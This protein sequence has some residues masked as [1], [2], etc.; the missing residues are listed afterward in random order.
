MDP[1]LKECLEKIDRRL[2][3]VERGV[4]AGKRSMRGLELAMIT[5]MNK[6]GGAIHDTRSHLGLGP[7][8]STGEE[9]DDEVT[10]HDSPSEKMK[11]EFEQFSMKFPDDEGA[12]KVK[13]SENPEGSRLSVEGDDPTKVREIIEAARKRHPVIESLRPMGRALRSRTGKLVTLTVGLLSA[14]A[15]AVQWLETH[16]FLK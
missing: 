5:V 14:L 8:Q 3:G 13:V 12:Y 4:R 10:P 7:W 11:L 16:G 9:S 2:E 1:E 6:L 15:G